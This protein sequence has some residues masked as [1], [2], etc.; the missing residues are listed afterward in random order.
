[1]D[2]YFLNTLIFFFRSQ[3]DI[4]FA[5]I[6]DILDIIDDDEI[7]EEDK[8]DMIMDVLRT[9]GLNETSYRGG[10]FSPAEYISP[11]EL[12]HNKIHNEIPFPLQAIR[13][14]VINGTIGVNLTL[15]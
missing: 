8:R 11:S 5:A 15:N 9:F 1:M 10:S 7:R 2:C 12:S 6:R 3:R 13:F 14:P 4:D